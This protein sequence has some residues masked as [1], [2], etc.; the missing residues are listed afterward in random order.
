[1]VRHVREVC[2]SNTPSTAVGST[3]FFTIPSNGVRNDWP[4]RCAARPRVRLRVEAD[5]HLVEELGR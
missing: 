5:L 2:E 1:M 4:T 3:P